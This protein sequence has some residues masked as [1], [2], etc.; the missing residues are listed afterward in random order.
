M[1]SLLRSIGL[2]IFIL[3]SFSSIASS[4][5]ITITTYYPSPYGSYRELR[6]TRVA[7]GDNYIDSSQYC[8]GGG[9]TNTID[10]NADLVV[11]GNVEIG[12]VT[13]QH[14]LAVAGTA[15][16][17]GR[18]IHLVTND[19]AIWG[20]NTNGSITRML[21]YGADNNVY[22]VSVPNSIVFRT[23]GDGTFF[24]RIIIDPAGN[25]GVG[26]M[27]PTAKL[28]VRA[29]SETT[30]LAALITNL[31]NSPSANGLSI[32]TTRWANDA[33]ALDVQSATLYVRSDGNVGIGTTTPTAKFDVAGTA[34]ADYLVVD[35]QDGVNEGGEIYLVGAGTNTEW[36][37]D[38]YQ[39]RFRW[40]HGGAEYMTL[41]AAGNLGVGTW[42]P[43][44]RITCN[45]EPGAN[46]YTAWT[47]YSDRRLKKDIKKIE[48]GTIG[49][50]MKLNPST[51]KY[52]DK[53][54]K[55]TGYSKKDGQR[56]MCGFL[57]QELKEVFPEMVNEMSLSGEIYLD[58]N[59]TNLQVYL[60]K[61]IQE[62]QEEIR[63]Q[64]DLIKNQQVQ[65]DNLKAR[66]DK[67]E[68]RQF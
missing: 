68:K 41:T 66:L 10:A 16:T 29:P 22:L 42:N 36:I 1:S 53:Y 37:L 32:S 56:K 55:L 5:D 44:Y 14:S 65:I 21:F 43:G 50:I 63:K 38:N 39:S 15:G 54:Y 40:H 47:N 18:G 26:I 2:S 11:E 62:Q 20:T 6:A 30:M 48:D 57:A 64:D 46:G 28:D 61:A 12:T 24:N 9:C 23:G 58:S 49:K 19:E 60:V 45:G 8:W 25:L 4:E 59:L 17:G 13:S 27:G 51:F 52:N 3:F 31:R 34:R 67:L 33:Y 35:P 7:I